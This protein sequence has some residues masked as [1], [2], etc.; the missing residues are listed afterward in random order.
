MLKHQH[1]QNT[2]DNNQISVSTPEPSN[3]TTV[4]PKNYNIAEAQNKTSKTAIMNMF[5]DLKEYL[6]KCIATF[7]WSLQGP[8]FP[9]SL[10]SLKILPPVR[11]QHPLSSL[12]STSQPFFTG[13]LYLFGSV[14]YPQKHF[15]PGSIHQF[16]YRAGLQISGFIILP[17]LHSVLSRITLSSVAT[18]L[19]EFSSNSTSTPWKLHLIAEE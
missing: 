10:C 12:L 15:L 2:V 7:I 1:N 17:A 14:T 4:H 13:P 8:P 16:L 6:N 11:N 19:Q 9:L 18:W 5:K 3:P